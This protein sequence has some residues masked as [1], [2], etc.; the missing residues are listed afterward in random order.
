LWSHPEWRDP[1]SSSL[2]HVHLNAIF[3]RAPIRACNASEGAFDT[4]LM[5]PAMRILRCE[6]DDK[7]NPGDNYT[8]SRTVG[9]QQLSSAVVQT[10]V[11]RF[12]DSICAA[13]GEAGVARR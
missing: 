3:V 6:P 4:R 11:E 13:V 9:S 10:R 5:E 7:Y 1:A 8:S 12:V 2:V